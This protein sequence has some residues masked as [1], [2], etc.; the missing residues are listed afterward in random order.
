MVG[1]L[2]R[3]DVQMDRCIMLRLRQPM[4][5]RHIQ[6]VHCLYLKRV[7]GRSSHKIKSITYQALWLCCSGI[8]NTPSFPEDFQDQCIIGRNFV[9]PCYVTSI[10]SESSHAYVLLYTDGETV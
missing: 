9:G 6:T 7:Y 5:T 3:N 10:A 4:A 1:K 8:E 2:R